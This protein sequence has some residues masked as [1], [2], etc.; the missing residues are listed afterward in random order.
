MLTHTQIDRIRYVHANNKVLQM[1][2]DLGLSKLGFLDIKEREVSLTSKAAALLVDNESIQET[3]STWESWTPK[4]E[5]YVCDDTN[6][7]KLRRRDI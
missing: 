5:P 4:E 1:R 3:L 2:G 6:H 7:F